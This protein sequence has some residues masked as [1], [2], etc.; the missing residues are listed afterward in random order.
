M[1]TSRKD[2]GLTSK[3]LLLDKGKS[4]RQR[5][6][7]AS[8]IWPMK[9]YLHRN[10][11]GAK[12]L[13]NILYYT[14][15]LTGDSILLRWA[16]FHINIKCCPLLK[17]HRLGHWL[18]CLHSQGWGHRILVYI[19]NDNRAGIQITYTGKFQTNQINEKK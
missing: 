15:S 2:G 5:C 17:H 4:D 19:Q 8:T 13:A 9:P 3:H 18:K 1:R 7:H 10:D 16:L 12:I 11:T 6:D 14:S